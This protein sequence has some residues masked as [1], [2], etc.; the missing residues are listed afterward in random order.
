MKQR[1]TVADV[2]PL[3]QPYVD[4]SRE[5]SREPGVH[6]IEGSVRAK[7]KRRSVDGVVRRQVGE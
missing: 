6:G 1:L 7:R 5:F 3:I 2:S 4:F